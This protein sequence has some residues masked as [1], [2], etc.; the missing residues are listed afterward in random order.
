[1]TVHPPIH[2]E[3][4]QCQDC[5][6]CI[7]H[8]PVKAIRVE[9]NHAKIIPELCVFCGQCVIDCPAHAKQTREDRQRVLHLLSE[10]KQVFV[11]LAPSFVSEFSDYTTQELIAVLKKLG[12]AGVS[13]TA[14]GADLVSAQ[15][16]K[17]LEEAVAN[18]QG[19]QLFLSSACPA[20]VEYIKLYQPELAPF[21]TDR[22]SPLLAHARYLRQEYGKD[23]GLVF[24]GPCIAK[25]RE[26]DIWPEIDVALTF[27]EL[28]EWIEEVGFRPDS[29]ISVGQENL[30]VFV[31]RP[32]AKGVLYP[33]DGGMIATYKKYN[34][35]EKVRSMAV[36]GL[37]EVQRAL[38]GFNPETLNAPVFMELLA[39]H[40]GCINGPGSSVQSPGALRRILVEE[41]AQNVDNTLDENTLSRS[42]ALEGTLPVDYSQNKRH[43]EE[44]IRAALRSVGKYSLE[45]EVNC[46]SCG[47]DTCRSFARAVL[48]NRAEKTMC[49]SYMRKLAQKKAN[50][51]I[52][53]IPSGVVIVDKNLKIVECN[54]N[55]ARLMGKDIVEMYQLRPGL[56]GADLTRLTF[57]AKLFADVL[58]RNGP[59]VIERDVREGKKIFH[60]T[61]F[62]IEREEIAAGVIEDITVP[63]NQ[64]ERTISQAQKVIEKNLSVVQKIAFLLGENAA[65]T[66][67]MLNSIIQSYGDGE[68]DSL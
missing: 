34:R 66:E 10:R 57:A 42:P 67:S 51:L 6:K 13:E 5:Y 25:K 8:C 36:S 58:T 26:A 15:L 29:V 52:Q 44:D 43:S 33:I 24:V 40:G 1:M 2:T 23:I 9:N 16:A 18:P 21:I 12:F 37:T 63:Q 22:A 32:A 28:R 65:E 19:Q 35:L 14:L 3:P 53:A 50:G 38:D 55:F 62:E 64:R 56:E 54:M 31:P 68:E 20:V 39:C 27:Q 59:D 48:E 30:Q 49:V 47:Y 41:Y 46:A 11:S 4:T 60:V 61:V 45:D 17:D 7:R